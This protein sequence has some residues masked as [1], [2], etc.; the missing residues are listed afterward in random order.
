MTS[1]PNVLSMPNDEIR[2]R[3]TD[4]VNL[5]GAM[6]TFFDEPSKL[7]LSCFS[8]PRYPPE[9]QFDVIIFIF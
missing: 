8:T 4:A 3:S 1:M 2:P 5:S 7:F 6:T 9:E